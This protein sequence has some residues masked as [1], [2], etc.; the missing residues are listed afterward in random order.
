MKI[1][2]AIF[3][4]DGTIVDVPY[5][6]IKI[7]AELETQGKPILIYLDSLEEPEKSMKWKILEK[8]ED[9]A[10]K[11][12]ELKPGIRKLLSFLSR[13]GIKKVLVTNNAEKNVNFLLNKFHLEFDLIVSRE[14]GLWKPSGAPFVAV[15]R[16]LGL[17]KKECC[18]VGDSHFDVQ[19]ANEAGIPY[20]F[21]LN[22]NKERFITS[23]V[24]VFSSPQELIKRLETLL[25]GEGAIKT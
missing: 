21:I 18:V 11:K 14:S 23:K 5:D 24:E 16:K 9:E 2:G 7:K 4:M 15:L 1:K 25:E 10:T 12:A 22:E 13:K 3:D 8:Y 19:A 20:V 17:R 6:W